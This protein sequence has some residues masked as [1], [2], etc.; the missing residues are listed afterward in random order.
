MWCV[1][2]WS[3]SK[4]TQTPAGMLWWVTQVEVFHKAQ[5]ETAEKRKEKKTALRVRA[6]SSAFPWGLDDNCKSD[7]HI[8]QRR[9]LAFNRHRSAIAHALLIIVLTPITED[10][11]KPVYE[12]PEYTH[13]QRHLTSGASRQP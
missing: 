7:A 9:G 5:V 2:N 8:S 3:G 12:F 6:W 4:I 11:P 1:R 10:Y 13:H